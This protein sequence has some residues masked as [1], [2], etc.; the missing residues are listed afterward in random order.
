MKRSYTYVNPEDVTACK[1]LIRTMIKRDMKRRC[2]LFDEDDAR[3]YEYQ[4][5]KFFDCLQHEFREDLK[6]WTLAEINKANETM[7]DRR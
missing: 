2:T 4:A 6:E 7:F 3:D 5:A 1:E